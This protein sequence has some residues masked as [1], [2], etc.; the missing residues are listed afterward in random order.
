MAFDAR[1]RAKA[2]SLVQLS[3][4]G[5]G[6]VSL[7]KALAVVQALGEQ[8]P[9]GLRMLLKAYMAGLERRL[10]Q[11]EARIEYA[12]AL[13][14]EALK[15]LVAALEKRHGRA[16][17]PVT[18]E[19]KALIAGIRARVGDDVYDNSVAARLSALRGALQ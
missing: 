12:G 13:D 9:R 1:T 18:R 7:E 16:L 10:A 8:R 3:L 17:T 11:S 2:R 14:K 15:T 6:A 5:G 19:N 4:D